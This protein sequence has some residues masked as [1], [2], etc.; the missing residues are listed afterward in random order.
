M[1]T[2]VMQE[3]LMLRP[4]MDGG[5]SLDH[6]PSRPQYPAPDANNNEMHIASLPARVS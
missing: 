5:G 3:Y 1:H 2:H 6:T 4:I